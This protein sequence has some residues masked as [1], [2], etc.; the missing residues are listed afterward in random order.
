[1]SQSRPPFQPVDLLK[2]TIKFWALLLEQDADPIRRGVDLASADLASTSRLIAELSSLL[3]DVS[4]ADIEDVRSGAGEAIASG[5][6]TSLPEDSEVNDRSEAGANRWV[7]NRSVLQNEFARLNI[8]KSDFSGADIRLLLSGENPLYET[9]LE[10][11]LSLSE[12]LLSC[13]ILSRHIYIIP[14]SPIY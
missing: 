1:M 10:T 13:K 11:I 2:Q 4:C 12:T 7:R 5:S 3:P 8:W 14:F 6:L 9:I